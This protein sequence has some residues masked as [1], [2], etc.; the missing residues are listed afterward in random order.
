MHLFN[1]NHIV[2]LLN[3]FQSGTLTSYLHAGVSGFLDTCY[4]LKSITIYPIKSCGGFSAKS[5]PLSNNG[6]NINFC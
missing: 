6:N 4:Y 2:D 1:S 3:I 5:W